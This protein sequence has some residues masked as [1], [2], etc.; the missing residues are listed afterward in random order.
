[1]L[2]ML[3]F[4]VL[5]LNQVGVEKGLKKAFEKGFASTLSSTHTILDYKL[6][7]NL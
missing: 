1:M 7:V 4:L 2:D 3:G 5:A 6:Y